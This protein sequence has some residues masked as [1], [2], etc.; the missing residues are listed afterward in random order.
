MEQIKCFPLWQQSKTSVVGTFQDVLWVGLGTVLP[1]GVL[2]KLNSL[3]SGCRKLTQHPPG[4]V[5]HENLTGPPLGWSL[6]WSDP[7]TVSSDKTD[8]S[9]IQM[10]DVSGLCGH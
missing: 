7:A 10:P 3:G 6:T 2:V 9:E 5:P 8:L 1:S 4:S